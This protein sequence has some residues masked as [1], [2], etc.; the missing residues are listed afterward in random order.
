MQM[1]RFN[2][3]WFAVNP[4]GAS[5]PR[6]LA[7][8]VYPV[9][10]ETARCAAQGFAELV[11]APEDLAAA[12][13]AADKAMAKADKAD[14]AAQAAFEALAA[15]VAAA[16]LLAEQTAAEVPPPPIFF[17]RARRPSSAVFL[18]V[19]ASSHLRPAQGS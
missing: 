3:T 1:H 6:Y 4:G 2:T 8:G 18:V 7:G 14:A 5:A 15:A 17:F 11:D 13:A 19:S 16:P 9:T 12:Q 10:E